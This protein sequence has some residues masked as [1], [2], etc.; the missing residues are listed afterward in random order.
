M[1]YSLVTHT[2]SEMTQDTQSLEVGSTEKWQ[3]ENRASVE[4]EKSLT[5]TKMG[6]GG[7]GIAK[8]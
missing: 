6:G 7:K 1:S 8:K 5:E 2:L 4:S 3:R